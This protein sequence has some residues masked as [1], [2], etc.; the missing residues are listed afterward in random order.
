MLTGGMITISTLIALYQAPYQLCF[1]VKRMAPKSLVCM[2]RAGR[3][4]NILGAV[5][6]AQSTNLGEVKRDVG[7]GQIPEAA[8]YAKVLATPAKIIKQQWTQTI[9]RN[10]IQP[11]S[12]SFVG[13]RVSRQCGVDVTFGTILISVLQTE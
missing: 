11:R 8:L 12:Q 4:E 3:I 9:H 6:C 13:L 7:C 10:L 2:I 1:L 5:G